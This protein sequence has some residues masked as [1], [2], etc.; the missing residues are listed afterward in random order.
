MTS[1]FDDGAPAWTTRGAKV[2]FRSYSSM[3]IR[4]MGKKSKSQTWLGT[5]G[6]HRESRQ[7]QRSLIYGASN[8]SLAGRRRLYI[9]DSVRGRLV[10]RH[11]RE[12]LLAGK[13][14]GDRQQSAAGCRCG[15]LR[16]VGCSPESGRTGNGAIR[17]DQ[18]RAR[19]PVANVGR[20]LYVDRTKNPSDPSKAGVPHLQNQ[21]NNRARRRIST[22]PL[23]LRFDIFK[24]LCVLRTS[25]A[26]SPPVGIRS[27]FAV[28]QYG[29]VIRD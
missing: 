14:A 23:D 7:R 1:T 24:F 21:K 18:T 6:H 28:P 27:N 22:A 16:Q 26:W 15:W 25:A 29:H 13:L 5:A 11:P 9:W 3:L 17:R 8:W 10:C 19:R 4:G 20:W 12:H 2:T